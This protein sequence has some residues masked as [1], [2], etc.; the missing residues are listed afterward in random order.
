MV[1]RLDQLDLAEVARAVDLGTPACLAKPVFVHCAHEVVIDAATYWIT[2][3]F[4]NVEGVNYLDSHS[5]HVFAAEDG[6]REAVDL[7]EWDVG[8]FKRVLHFY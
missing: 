2:V 4:V 7:V 5:V 8:I 6:K 3:G 1:N